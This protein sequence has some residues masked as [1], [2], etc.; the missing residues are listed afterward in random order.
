MEC[1]NIINVYIGDRLE[2]YSVVLYEEQN[3]LQDLPYSQFSL[4]FQWE[5]DGEPSPCVSHCVRQNIHVIALSTM[6]S[7]SVSLTKSLVFTFVYGTVFS[8]V[9]LATKYFFY[10]C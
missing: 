9:F 4:V 3:G 10:K 5:A 7:T 2:T 1:Y 8:L 6:P